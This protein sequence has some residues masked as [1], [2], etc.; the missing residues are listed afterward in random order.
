MPES[1]HTR[2]RFVS[3]PI[4]PIA[5]SIETKGMRVGSVALPLRFRWGTTEFTITEVLDQWYETGPMK[6]GGPERY[7]RTHW[8]RIRTTDGE[9]MSIYFE[10]QARSRRQ[11]KK[12]WWLYSIVVPGPASRLA[13]RTDGDQP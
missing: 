12:R 13:V 2:E 10:R 3:Q 11:V 5:G 6:G 8:F 9:G 4:T 1:T 7:L